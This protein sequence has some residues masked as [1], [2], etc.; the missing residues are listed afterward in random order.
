MPDFQNPAAFLLLLLIPVLYL[1]RYVGFFSR[2]SFLITLSDWNGKSFPWE[3]KSRNFASMFSRVCGCIGFVVTVV[4]LA[5]PILYRQERVYTSRGTDVMFVIDVSPSMSAKDIG[6]ITRLEAA[7]HAV[8]ELVNDNFGATFGVVAMGEESSIVIPPTVDKKIFHERLSGLSLGNLGNGTAIGTGLATAVFHLASSNAPKKCIVLVTDGENNAG[9][10]H[11]ETAAEL[12]SKNNITVYTLGVG[13]TGS[14]PI[15]YIDPVTGKSYTGFLN[16]TF[17]VNSLRQIAQV[18]GGRFFEI[19]AISDFSLALS[20][21]IKNQNVVQTYH[22]KTV[23]YDFYDK[24]ILIAGIMFFLSWFVRRIC[25][26]E[27]I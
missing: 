20:V 27:F 2:M 3:K 5:D 22:S 17:D 6:G 18:G 15:E 9:A 4:A 7:K 16:S 11:P 25:L 8:T 24:L 19:Q 10:I 23:N 13:T 12:A 26:Q 14:V 21:I 1:L